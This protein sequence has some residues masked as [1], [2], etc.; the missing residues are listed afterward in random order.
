M[1]TKL[2]AHAHRPALGTCRS[3]HQLV[4][5][6]RPCCNLWA[7]MPSCPSMPPAREHHTQLAPLATC[8]QER[9]PAGDQRPALV[10]CGL[11]RVLVHRCCQL[12]ARA[13]AEADCGDAAG[14][15]GACSV[16]VCGCVG[17]GGGVWMGEGGAGSVWCWGVE[18]KCPP[19]LPAAIQCFNQHPIRTCGYTLNILPCLATGR[20]D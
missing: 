13:R 20:R 11:Q 16:W 8:L 2:H 4:L 10:L 6:S 5:S 3:G 7:T 9:A 14:C 12:G 17:V 19:S 18:G 15:Q 1:T